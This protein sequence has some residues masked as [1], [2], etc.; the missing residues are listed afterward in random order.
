M[1]TVQRIHNSVRLA[2]YADAWG[3]DVEFENDISRIPH[4]LPAPDP[5]LITDDTQMSIAVIRGL[6]D[7]AED[8]IDESN[9]IG[10]RF[11]H[12]LHD[13]DNNRAPGMTCVQAI[14]R[15]EEY[16]RRGGVNPYAGGVFGRKGCGANMRAPWI[17]LVNV[18]ASKVSQ[19]AAQQA[20]ITHKHDT[21]SVSAELTALATWKI[22]RGETP[23]GELVQYLLT[24]S[25]KNVEVQ[26]ALRMVQGISSEQWDDPDFDLG[27]YSPGWIAE[28]ALASAA[29]AYDSTMEPLE[30]VERVIRMSGDSDSVGFIAG[31]FLGAGEADAIRTIEEARFEARYEEELR[32]VEDVISRTW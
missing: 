23:R 8:P 27:D 30:A 11:I 28:Q 4:P 2:A 22:F 20:A 15:L 21:A 5:L 6:F 29:R 16:R 25:R 32:Q 1:S 18:P 19:W 26:Q 13:P 12:W 31:A 3:K 10:S 9:N 17:G 24:R 14:K 7:P